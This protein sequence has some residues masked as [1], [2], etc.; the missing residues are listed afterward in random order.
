M[1][2]LVAEYNFYMQLLISRILQN[3]RLTGISFRGRKRYYSFKIGSSR[4]SLS[5]S[6]QICTS[7]IRTLLIANAT[8]TFDAEARVE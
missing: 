6:H 8:T 1:L 3:N 7:D 4:A 5:N 2:S